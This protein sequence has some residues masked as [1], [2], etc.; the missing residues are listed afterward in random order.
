M[1]RVVLSNARVEEE[2]Q[3][4]FIPR[5]HPSSNVPWQFLGRS[6]SRPLK[7]SQ[8]SPSTKHRSHRHASL[9]TS[10]IPQTHLQR[11]TQ[12]LTFP[13][14]PVG[15]IILGSYWRGIY[16]RSSSKVR[17]SRRLRSSWADCNRRT[18]ILPF[19]FSLWGV[20]MVTSLP[21]RNNV[22]DT[23]F[24]RTPLVFIGDHLPT[25]IPAIF[26][27]ISQDFQGCTDLDVCD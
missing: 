8:G 9:T 20:R 5:S 22:S 24:W 21:S 27:L 6:K 14:K 1:V 15:P 23:R 10:M 11:H 16:L 19:R 17:R 12:S 25:R 4:I 13:K 7:T 2:R 18:L 3:F 26:V